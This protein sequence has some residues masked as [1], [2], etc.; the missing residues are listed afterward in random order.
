MGLA[1]RAQGSAKF[2]EMAV[3]IQLAGNSDGAELAGVVAQLI[4]QG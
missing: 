2:S 3:L 1:E 4:E